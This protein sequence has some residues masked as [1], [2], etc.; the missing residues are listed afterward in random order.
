MGVAIAFP[1]ILILMILQTTFAKQIT[2]LNGS[3]DLILVWLAAW[4]IQRQVKNIWLWV[5]FASLI[6]MLV[7][8]IPWYVPLISYFSVALCAR[9]ITR[10]L[11]QAPLLGMFLTTIIGSLIMYMLSFIILKF[12]GSIIDFQQSLIQV[13]IPSV[14]LNLIISLPLYLLAKDTAKWVYP[15]EVENE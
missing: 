1:T 11:W 7:S 12:T 14:L 3:A 2:L 15:L 8:A 5:A 6:V 4:G 9:V 10:N 13:I